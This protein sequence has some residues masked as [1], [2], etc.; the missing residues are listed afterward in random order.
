MGHAVRIAIAGGGTGGH[1]FPALGIAEAIRKQ[2]P[3]A[4][5]LFFGTAGKIE[6]TVVPQRGFPFRTI[7]ISGFHRSLRPANLLFPAKLVVSL[8]QSWL[9][10]RSFRPDVV[11][12][13]G[14]YVCGPV[15][16]V[17]SLMGLPTVLHESN[18]YPGA[19]TR[20]LAGRVAKVLTG[21]SETLVHLPS[22][23]N[24]EV[25]GTPVR[26]FSGPATAAEAKRSFGF[27][28]GD[29]VV[30]VT[31]GSQGSASMN[32]AIDAG[33]ND[34]TQ[35]GIRT[36]WQTGRQ[37]EQH[38]GTKYGSAPHVRV[39]GF[40]DDVGMAY[41]AADV[42]VSRSGAST[43]AE[44]AIAG[45]PAI[46]VPYPFAADDHQMK[47]A[48]AVE[49]KGAAIVVPNGEVRERLIGDMMRLCADPGLRTNM[50]EAMKRLAQPAAADVIAQ[51]ILDMV[52]SS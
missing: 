50:A 17:A 12:G 44:L 10:L 15:L 28:V 48:R 34:L 32:E 47:N 30:F 38:Y 16:W 40:V 37:Q 8:V 1:V 24:A 49:Q 26:K 3:D 43:L 21:F 23:A 6:A 52:P 4:A 41:S 11:V 25:V 20:M 14:G 13:T 9:A 42:V 18:S 35:A 36:I 51:K 27:G 19:T 29:R 7:W 22:A 2:M 31:G 46:L 33:M 5:F 45:K 39:M